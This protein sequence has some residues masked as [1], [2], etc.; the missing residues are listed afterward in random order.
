M[1]LAGLPQH[2]QVSPTDSCTRGMH[3]EETPASSFIFSSHSRSPH[4]MVLAKPPSVSIKVLTS[5]RV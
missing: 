2:T 4:H 5:S 3:R 1:C